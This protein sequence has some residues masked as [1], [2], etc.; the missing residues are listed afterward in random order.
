MHS[1]SF[2][3]CG[4][5]PTCVLCATCFR[6][7]DHIGH[8]I[9]YNITNLPGGC[10]DCG[11]NEAWLKDMHCAVHNIAHS[12]G[13]YDR[14][15]NYLVDLKDSELPLFKKII[16]ILFSLYVPTSYSNGALED[17]WARLQK[18]G[19]PLD[20]HSIDATTTVVLYNDESHSFEEVILVLKEAINCSNEVGQSIAD[21]VDRNGR[22]SV[23]VFLRSEDHTKVVDTIRAVGLEC[24]VIP[25]IVL[26]YSQGAYTL[27]EWLIGRTSKSPWLQRAISYMLCKAWDVSEFTFYPL[28]AKEADFEDAPSFVEILFRTDHRLWKSA[29]ILFKELLMATMLKSYQWKLELARLFTKNYSRLLRVFM[30]DEREP[31]FSI[32]FFSVQ[33]YTVP[34]IV[35]DLVLNHDLVSKIVGSVNDALTASSSGDTMNE[36]RVNLDLDCIANR[37]YFHPFQDIKYILEG[38]TFHDFVN[39]QAE[40]SPFHV[41]FDFLWIFE[42]MNINVRAL[43]SHVEFEDDQWTNAFNM[44]LQLS[45]LVG[46]LVHFCSKNV[47]DVFETFKQF[48]SWLDS[49]ERFPVISPDTCQIRL[50]AGQ[51]SF[52]HP[53]HWFAGQLLSLCT[54]HLAVDKITGR[55]HADVA[56][57]I[58]YFV[59]F[60]LMVQGYLSQ[61]RAGLWVRNGFSLK[62]QVQ[63]YCSIHMAE[64]IRDPDLLLL[65]LYVL[66]YPAESLPI[67]ISNFNVLALAQNLE[68]ANDEE[69]DVFSIFAEDLM[70]FLTMI[71]SKDLCGKSECNFGSDLERHLVHLLFCYEGLS[72]SE[73]SKK[74]LPSLSKDLDK[75]MKALKKISVSKTKNENEA[76]FLNKSL[77]TDIDLF[78]LYYTSNERQ[79]CLDKIL[80]SNDFKNQPLKLFCP[81][82]SSSRQ[83]ALLTIFVQSK[84]FALVV[85]CLLKCILRRRLER[86]W[87]LL[88]IIYLFRL[89][90]EA[91]PKDAK[92]W[93]SEADVSEITDPPNLLETL[94]VKELLAEIVKEKLCGKAEQFILNVI[95]INASEIDAASPSSKTKI[96][97]R[98]RL[99]MEQF[100]K[101][102]ATFLETFGDQDDEYDQKSSSNSSV[103]LEDQ[104]EV[105]HNQLDITGECIICRE[106][107]DQGGLIG[108]LC[109]IDRVKILRE[110]LPL[111][112]INEEE[113]GTRF[114]VEG[115]QW[116]SF[117]SI[118]VAGCRHL[119]HHK[120]ISNGK[121]NPVGDNAFTRFVEQL[122]APD[123][124]TAQLCIKKCP[125]CRRKVEYFLPIEFPGSGIFGDY[126]ALFEKSQGGDMG[127]ASDFREAIDASLIRHRNE[128]KAF[129][130]FSNFENATVLRS[131]LRTLCNH[132]NVEISQLLVDFIYHVEVFYRSYPAADDDIFIITSKYIFESL[133]FLMKCSLMNIEEDSWTDLLKQKLYEDCPS[134]ALQP[135]KSVVIPCF[136]LL[137]PFE[138]KS[139][140]YFKSLARKVFFFYVQSLITVTKHFPDIQIDEDLSE[141]TN[142]ILAFI[143]NSAQLTFLETSVLCS[144]SLVLLRQLAI[145]SSYYFHIHTISSLDVKSLVNFFELESAIASGEVILREN[146]V[147]GESMAFYPLVYRIINLPQRFD[148]LALQTLKIPCSNCGKVPSEPA[149]CLICGKL[150][151]SQSYCCTKIIPGQTAVGECNIHMNEE[152]GLSTGIF[153][154][155]QRAATLYLASKFRGA[156]KGGPYV[157]VYGET[158]VG[159]RRGLPLFLR[160]ELVRNIEYLWLTNSVYNFTEVINEDSVGFPRWWFSM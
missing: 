129:S 143:G 8:Q 36:R 104:K 91:F 111:H 140:S 62:S 93:I 92:A 56:R 33:L 98:K 2:R 121:L 67:Y 81:K 4:R 86:E 63:N 102:Q 96:L 24:Q 71:V 110:L 118:F 70:N 30:N 87:I 66:H 149:I 21:E 58:G 44:S 17:L 77:A 157:D 10:C 151:C 19:S 46:Q 133:R 108:I 76:F 43:E 47:Q 74:L 101:Q 144:I 112:L 53:L 57:I 107:L 23:R 5:D 54:H 9:S 14:D 99:L 61:I 123:N 1:F 82:V 6:Y 100:E 131:L 116:K 26:Y 15:D 28:A 83:L 38:C 138:P 65:Q 114:F 75:T 156:T 128:N 3:E 18:T 106:N 120:C 16:D 39:T 130:S 137:P 152:C 90:Q 55:E 50:D 119:V 158:D 155:V 80:S 48:S 37:R 132:F 153:L 113:Q 160:H 148:Q 13:N 84:D 34:S 141:L 134:D 35:Q 7:E 51:F 142:V 40:S 11:D 22:A 29:R 41:L 79:I 69:L 154:M 126:S 12:S 103:S 124:G 60:P 115:P 78:F 136:M 135:L 88:P 68:N 146:M 94:S 89:F 159:F 147:E 122:F 20:P 59:R 27:L 139:V 85:K 150:C 31:E 73:I 64:D 145:F 72:F 32:L 49:K 45:D 52:H 105:F 127:V 117:Q 42:D 109:D 125:V 95:P 97:D 25:S